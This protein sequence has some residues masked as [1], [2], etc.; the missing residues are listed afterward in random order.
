M[1]SILPHSMAL[2]Y[3]LFYFRTRRAANKIA[4]LSRLSDHNK[5]EQNG[6]GRDHCKLQKQRHRNLFSPRESRFQKINKY[7]Y[8]YPLYSLQLLVFA[9][10]SIHRSEWSLE[11]VQRLQIHCNYNNYYSN[12]NNNNN[13]NDQVLMSFRYHAFVFAAVKSG[14]LIST[15]FLPRN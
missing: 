8:S 10:L 12:N 3:V 5:N 1:T 2:S 11:P 15:C 4:I 13:N 6:R 9:R 14:K 7:F